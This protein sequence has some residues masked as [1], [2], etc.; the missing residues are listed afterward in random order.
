[1][2]PSTA[3]RDSQSYVLTAPQAARHRRRY[4]VEGRSPRR[5]SLVPRLRKVNL[6]QSNFVRTGR[7]QTHI[8]YVPR[9]SPG[10]RRSLRA[11]LRGERPSL[12]LNSRVSTRPR[13]YRVARRHS[14]YLVGNGRFT[15]KPKPDA[16]SV[17]PRREKRGRTGR[18]GVGRHSLSLS[19]YMGDGL[20]KISHSGAA[21][22]I[23]G[24]VGF[25][26]PSTAARV[27]RLIGSDAAA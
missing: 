1:L 11:V 13:L 25:R 16:W 27:F 17:P 4:S 14:P 2:S 18:M 10:R 22:P 8:R 24:F 7:I 21:E 6:P 5:P 9:R 26:N 19:L 12:F 15:K 3:S 23:P 20:S